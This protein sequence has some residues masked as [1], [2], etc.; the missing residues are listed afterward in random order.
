MGHRPDLEEELRRLQQLLPGRAGRIIAKVQS[1]AAKPY[2]IPIGVGLTIGGV[3]G[4]LPIVGFWMVPLGLAVLA[5]DVPIMRAPTAR[6]VA[7][8]NRRLGPRD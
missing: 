8:I 4:F 6:V 7:A 5:Q 2:R 3:V 1:P